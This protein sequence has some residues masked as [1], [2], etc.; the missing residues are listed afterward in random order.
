MKLL[1]LLPLFLLFFVAACDTVDDSRVVGGVDLD[2]LFAP[3]T[4]AEVT[5]VQTEWQGRSLTPADVAVVQTGTI[6]GTSALG[7]SRAFEV[8]ILSH[9][10]PGAASGTHYGAVLIPSGIG[11]ND[12]LPVVMYLHGG[13]G[14]T[15]V[16]EAA[17]IAATLSADGESYIWIAPAFRDEPLRWGTQTWTSSGPASPWDFDV[18]DAL[19]LLNA[20]LAQVPQADANRIGAAGFSRGGA[21]GLLGAARD[22]RVKRVLAIFP[23]TNFFGTF[24]QEVVEDALNGNARNLPGFDVLNARFIQPLKNGQV[25]LPQMR[26]ELLRRSPIAFVDR[27]PTVQLHHGTADDIVP[28]SQAN[29]F[30]NAMRGKSTFSSFI[31]QGG[32]HNPATF[33]IN[34]L[35]ESQAFLGQL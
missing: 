33:P 34:W 1:R 25:T 21:V 32:Q 3:P 30:I 24:V 10:L 17:T 6:T 18:D 8:R 13:D 19:V 14:G 31:W 26:L 12:R 27:M 4:A 9:R 28:V 29:D 2:A 20:T 11:P 35:L 16:Q 5:Q 22:N 15:S 7:S 23:P